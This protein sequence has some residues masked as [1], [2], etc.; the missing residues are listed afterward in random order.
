LITV[1]F[2]ATYLPVLPYLL[3]FPLC[4]FFPPLDHYHSDGSSEARTQRCVNPGICVVHESRGQDRTFFQNSQ[5]KKRA[6]LPEVECPS[7]IGVEQ[8]YQ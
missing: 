3:G 7:H 6:K 5:I 2:Q 8:T 1:R 4:C